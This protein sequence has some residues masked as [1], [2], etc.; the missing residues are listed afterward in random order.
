MVGESIELATLKNKVSA[1]KPKG[2]GVDLDEHLSQ[3]FSFLIKHYPDSALAKFE[4]VSYLLR[5]K[6]NEVGQWLRTGEMKDFKTMMA[7]N[8]AFNSLCGPLFA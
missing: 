3:V 2:E 1:I 4:E 7:N 6:P 8:A 5:K